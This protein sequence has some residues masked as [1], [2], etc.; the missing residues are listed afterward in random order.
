MTTQSQDRRLRTPRDEEIPSLLRAL[1]AAGG[2]T[3]AFAR[4]HGV[5]PWKLYKAQRERA[6][7]RGRVKAREVAEEFVRVEIVD[8]GRTAPLELVL[9]G[10]G[11]LLLPRD[12]DESALRRLIGVLRS[13]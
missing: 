3:A 10:V 4:E 8:E 13:C 9:E 12:F 2:N 7:R 11:R 1:D 6:A 5:T